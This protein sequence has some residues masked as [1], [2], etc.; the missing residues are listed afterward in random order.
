MTMT[1]APKRIQDKVRQLLH[2]AATL[3]D[4]SADRLFVITLSDD[5]FHKLADRSQHMR[6][7]LRTEFGDIRIV[8]QREGE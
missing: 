3:N 2:E 7:T 6:E 8:I 5:D 4:C 1:T